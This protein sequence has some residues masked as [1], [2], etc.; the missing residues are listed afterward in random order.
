[1]NV[2]HVIDLVF[3]ISLFVL[4][5]AALSP[6]GPLNDGQHIGRCISIHSKFKLVVIL[7]W[8]W[9]HL[10]AELVQSIRIFKLLI[11]FPNW[12]EWLVFHRSFIVSVVI[13]LSTKFYRFH[14][15]AKL[16]LAYSLSCKV[17]LPTPDSW[18]TAWLTLPFETA[19][20]VNA[21]TATL[22]HSLLV[23]QLIN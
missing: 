8:I 20:V 17:W 18:P 22:I 15:W 9:R 1:M 14:G 6:W 23:L 13:K 16:I 3:H 12:F 10:A 2:G 21:A 11:N 7:I 19:V 4:M 5:Q